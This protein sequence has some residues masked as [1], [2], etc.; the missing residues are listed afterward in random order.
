MART[1]SRRTLAQYVAQRLVAGDEPKKLALLVTA[2]LS[3]T[4]RTNQLE[5]LIRDIE[6]ALARDHDA[7][8]LRL[9]AVRPL[10]AQ[11]RQKLA[12]FVREAEHAEQVIVTEETVDESLI[13]GVI[14][15]TPNG[16]FDNSIRTALRQLQATTKE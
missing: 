11:T 13:G 15:E 9:T 4:K 8:T 10:D 3:D 2:Y 12:A 5:L 1:F 7:V 14:A 16:V 6:G